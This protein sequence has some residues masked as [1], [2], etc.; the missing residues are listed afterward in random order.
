MSDTSLYSGLRRWSVTPG[1]VGFV[2]SPGL[3]RRPYWLYKW[4]REIDPVHRS[5][6]GVWLLSRHEDVTEALRNHDL[7][8][9]ETKADLEPL[10]RSMRI[11]G[12]FG[13]RSA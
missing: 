7:G 2:A 12:L 10:R 5:P 13:R 8:S 3:R 1:V 4:L 6:F 11:T 9:D